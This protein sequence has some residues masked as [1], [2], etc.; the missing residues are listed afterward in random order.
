[1]LSRFI[2]VAFVAGSLAVVGCSSHAPR[3]DVDFRQT[4]T[5]QKA[6]QD[7]STPAQMGFPIIDAHVHTRF[8]HKPEVNSGIIY[9]K[10]VLLKEMQ[11]AGIGG[12]ISMGY[13]HNVEQEDLRSNGIFQ[14]AGV[15]ADFKPKVLEA[16]LQKHQYQCLK[17]YLG[18]VHKF[19]SDSVY[20]PAYQLASKYKIPVVFHTGD[21]Y[22]KDGLLKYSDPL[23]IDEVAVQYRDVKFVIAHMGN[24]WIQSAAEVAYKNPNVYLEGSAFFAGPVQNYAP[25]RIQAQ[26][27]NSIRWVFEYVE[28]P[29]KVL[30]GTDWPLVP[31]KHY[32]AAFQAAIPEQH[33]KAVFFE[34]ARA[35]YKLPFTPEG[36]LDLPQLPQEPVEVPRVGTNPDQSPKM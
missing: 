31:M 22:D 4:N 30:F 9:S 23:T 19:A 3:T 6:A 29:R 32:L 17:I 16:Q 2:S 25:E 20:H 26:M 27:V 5:T 14:C 18:Y 11:E 15:R 28:D 36:T 35:V 24:P 34:N 21:I 8:N 10:D 13:N 33:W 1:M 12:A 7:F